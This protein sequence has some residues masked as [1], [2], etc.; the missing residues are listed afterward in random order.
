MGRFPFGFPKGWFQVLW[1]NE[2][3]DAQTVPLRSFAEDWLAWRDPEG[4][5]HVSSAYC[6]HL[7][8]NL[9]AGARVTRAGLRCPMHGWV[10]NS[11]GALAEIP[12]SA[13][14]PANCRLSDLPTTEQNGHILVWYD[15]HGQGPLW[16]VPSVPEFETQEFGGYFHTET[17]RVRSACQE[18]A[19]NLVDTRHVPWLHNLAPVELLQVTDTGPLREILLRQSIRSAVGEVSLL[20]HITCSGLG[21]TIVWFRSSFDVCTVSSITPIDEDY[22]DVRFSW[23]APRSGDRVRNRR[24][25]M[26]IVNDM[27]RVFNEDKPIWETRRYLQHPHLSAA[28]GPIGAFRHW[29]RQFY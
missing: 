19:E 17:I 23:L 24:V 1:S 21:H 4:R 8:T 18:L 3:G 2:L 29:C 20:A 14:L 10:F 11:D 15:P 9:Q 7:G 27:L 13:K 25:S 6:P 28:D 16:A 5:A 26:Q 12:Y 22:V